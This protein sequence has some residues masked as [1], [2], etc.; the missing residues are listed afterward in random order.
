[1]RLKGYLLSIFLYIVSHNLIAENT[2]QSFYQQEFKPI[3]QESAQNQLLA[4]IVFSADG[5]QRFIE[6]TFNRSTYGQEILPHDF[7]HIL[8]FLYHGQKSASKPYAKSVFKLFGNKLKGATYVNA[9]AF[10]HLLKYIGPLLEAYVKPAPIFMFN[11]IKKQINDFLYSSFLT[12]FD[13]FK[14]IQIHSLEI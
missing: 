11:Q 6:L 1:M 12:Q 13:L 10:A 8:Q 14:K 2:Q 5:V 7:R 9:Y 4:P 3:V